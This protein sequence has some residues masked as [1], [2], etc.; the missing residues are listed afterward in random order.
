M[1]FIDYC[2]SHRILLAIYPPHSTHTLQPLDVYLFRP[3]SQAYSDQLAIFMDQCQGLSSITKRDFFRLFWHAWNTS[4]T[5]ENIFSSFKATSLHPFN[6]QLVITKFTKNTEDRPSSASSRGSAIAA[7]DWK[8]IEKLLQNVVSNIYDKKAQKLS[9]T[10]HALSIENMLLKQQNNS[11]KQSLVNEKKRRK[12]S[13]P[14]LLDVPTENDGGAMFFSPTKVQHARD[15]QAQK[16]ANA[17]AERHQK[18]V[19]KVRKEAEKLERAQKVKE[20]KATRANM[21][22]LKLRKL[23]E[24]RQQKD[25]AIQAKQAS[26]QLH[27]ELTIRAKKV[28]KP[29][30]AQNKS[31]PRGDIDLVVVE[32]REPPL[33]VNTHGR[34]IRLPKR[35]QATI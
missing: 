16:D 32:D 2:D 17:I 11:L 5:P 13:K 18:E 1:K 28:Q 10:M 7:E 20:R 34:Q 30:Q 19:D 29:M 12:R 8:R 4:F 21:K 6:P 14:L 15:Q 31:N 27:S 24:K 3:L 22:E 26:Q 23:A 9:N 25:D 35:Y 33:P